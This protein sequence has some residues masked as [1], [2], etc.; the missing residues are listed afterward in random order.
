MNAMRIVR[1]SLLLSSAFF[2]ACNQAPKP[3]AS[4][5]IEPPVAAPTVAQVPPYTARLDPPSTTAAPTQAPTPTAQAT[6]TAVQ[7]ATMSGPQKLEEIES[8]QG[9]FTIASRAFTVVLHTQRIPGKSGDSAETLALLE[10]VDAGGNVQYRGEFPHT[11]ENGEYPETCSAGVTF[12]NGSNGSGLLLDEACLP[13]APLSGGPWRVLGL[14]NGKLTSLGKPLYAQGEMGDFVPG[15]ITRIGA[16]TQILPDEL[17]IRLFTGYFFVSV[18]VRVNWLQGKL[19]LAQH[20]FYQT[21]HGVAE[22]GC[23]MPADGVELQPSAEELT[24]VRMFPES[25]EQIGP[26]AHV[27]V[28]KNSKVEVLLAKALVQMNDQKDS[29]G[30]DVGGDIWV[31]VRIDGKVGWIHTNEDLQAIGLYQS[32]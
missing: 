3:T 24:F 9:P 32:G 29:I 23:E 26:P 5:R 4:A 15:K 20:C 16:L 2:T 21:G 7:S 30:L 22:G 25:N 10:V 12:L 17:R 14:V 19:E 28:K 6:P 8:R 27:V 18:P 31:Q 11:P 13:S 1:V